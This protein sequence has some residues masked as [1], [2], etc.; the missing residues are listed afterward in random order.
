MT[1]T[2]RLAS[3]RTRVNTSGAFGAAVGAATAFVA[4]W[5]VA[6]LAGW[7]TAA[8]V[9]VIWVWANVARMEGHDT[10]AVALRED[11]SRRLAD[12]I[13]TG[14]SLGCLVG[15]GFTLVKADDAHGAGRAGLMAIAVFSIVASWLVV[16]TV[17][18]LRYARLYYSDPE[19]GIGFDGDDAPGFTDFAY[20]AFT[21]GMTYQV[22]DT[23][24][25]SRPMRHTALKHALLSFVFGT[26][27]LAAT[28]NALAGLLHA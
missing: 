15:V 17:F 4:P 10:R 5:Q 28:I 11:P 16:Q 19:G 12:L 23:N 20:V 27:I 14:A 21:I 3:A 25:S 2:V 24:L 13:L 6:A 7:D 9:F 1:E 22:S 26:F 8:A 18:T